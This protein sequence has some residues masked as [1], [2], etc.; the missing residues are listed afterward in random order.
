MNVNITATSQ[1]TG[2]ENR[3]LTHEVGKSGVCGPG[4]DLLAG[5]DRHHPDEPPLHQV[6]DGPASQ[7]P[8]DLQAVL[9]SISTSNVQFKASQAQIVDSKGAGP[10]QLSVHQSR[11]T[12]FNNSM[13][14]YKSMVMSN[15]VKHHQALA[16]HMSKSEYEIS[17]TPDINHHHCT[18]HPSYNMAHQAKSAQKLPPKMKQP[19]ESSIQSIHNT[20]IYALFRQA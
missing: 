3:Q 7:R 9:T 15:H 6:L 20:I 14:P 4:E 19:N 12:T 10:G 17:V 16:L 18:L 8:V 1:S 2:L 11:Q 13:K 5:V